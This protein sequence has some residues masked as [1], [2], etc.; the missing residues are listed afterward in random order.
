MDFQTSSKLRRKNP[1]AEL[2]KFFTSQYLH[3]GLSELFCDGRSEK[4]VK[5]QNHHFHFNHKHKTVKKF[6][7]IYVVMMLC[8]HIIKLLHV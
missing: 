6:L 7:D 3:L 4:L 5:S 1:Q 8:T 2:K